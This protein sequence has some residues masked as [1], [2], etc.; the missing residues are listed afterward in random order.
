LKP[1]VA[2]ISSRSALAEG[3]MIVNHERLDIRVDSRV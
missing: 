3:T 1:A 2:A